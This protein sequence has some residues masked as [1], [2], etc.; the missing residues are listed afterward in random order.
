MTQQIKR[1]D[2]CA[3]VLPGFALKARAEHEP[4]GSHFVIMAKD[5]QTTYAY[6]LDEV[7]NDV[8]RMSINH[9]N[10]ESYYV[11]QGDVLFISRG[12]R[13]D[14]V[15][16]NS[17]PANTVASS[18]FYLLRPK[19]NIIPDYLAWY[20]NQLNVFGHLDQIRT[21]AGSPIVQRQSV[22]EFP[23]VVPT[24]GEQRQVAELSKLMNQQRVMQK[25]LLENLDIFHK[26]IN[27]KL[28]T[29]KLGVK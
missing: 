27:E 1:I 14:A 29:Q 7:D 13:N 12:Y 26:G 23:I 19:S 10:I 25:A 15:T 6:S 24:L 4:K 22:K 16:I 3:D 28:F 2:E 9:K 17:V 5:I 8:L 21:G 18:T 11:R 20:I